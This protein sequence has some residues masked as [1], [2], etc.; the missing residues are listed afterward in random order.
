MLFLGFLGAAA[1]PMAMGV[2]AS[3][4]WVTG[5]LGA[6]FA[7]ASVAVA[8]RGD[9]S[10]LAARLGID[11]LGERVAHLL[12]DDVKLLRGACQFEK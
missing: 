11:R 12:L 9:P 4:E 3:E 6:T 5:L 8:R 1:I 2:G 7:A 10:R